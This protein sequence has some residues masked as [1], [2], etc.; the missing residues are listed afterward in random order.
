MIRKD[1]QALRAI[2]VLAVFAYHARPDW[3]PGGFAGVDVF[4]VV[5][6]FLITSHLLTELNKTG[7]ISLRKFFARRAKRLLPASLAVLG[8]STA[9]VWTLAPLALQERFYRDIAAAALYVANWVF[10]ADAVD[11]LGKGNS[12]SIV[13]HFW[14]LGVEE[15]LYFVWPIGLIAV[16]VGLR[17]QRR[18]PRIMF[19]IAGV[20]AASFAYSCV[21]VLQNN[22]LAYFSTLSRAWEFGLGALLATFVLLSPQKIHLSGKSTRALGWAGWTSIAL[23]IVIFDANHGFPGWWALIPVLGTIA[24]IISSNPS[25]NYGLDK[26]VE[27][28]PFQFLGNVS[29]SFYLWHWPL[30]VVSGFYFAR[31]PWYAILL[32]FAVALLL[33][34]TSYKFIENPFRFGKLASIR[35]SQALASVATIMVLLVSAAQFGAAQAGE[36]L[37]SKAEQAS[38][39]ERQVLERIDA[40]QESNFGETVPEQVWDEIS[41]LGPAAIV[42][43]DC[44]QITWDSFVPAVGA[45]DRTAHEI[46]PLKMSGSKIGCL[47]WKDRYD[48]ITCT[49]GVLGGERWVLLGDSHAYQWLPAMNLVAQSNNIELIVMARAGCPPNTT[50]RDAIW[51]HQQ[52]CLSWQGEVLQW[53]S[54]S[55]TPAKVMVSNFAGTPF[56]GGVDKWTLNERAISGYQEFWKQLE[57]NGASIVAFRDTPFPG[58]E[59][60]GCIERNADD[61]NSC[62]LNQAT[63]EKVADNS[64]EA[65]RRAGYPVIDMWPYFCRDTVC[66]IVNG[67]VLTYKDSNHFS[68]TYGLL[69][70]DYLEVELRKLDL[71]SNK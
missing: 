59:A 60:W 14:S 50:K 46:E 13:Q 31:V 17:K 70:S 38:V 44:D 21:L 62:S 19:A 40:T 33:A 29:Y 9:V 10:A 55:T 57:E 28:K 34:Y 12:P 64:L 69:L 43:S 27:F 4:F 11:Y 56:L 66:D 8:F 22:P 25:S 5:S 2:A 65:A 58:D 32:V 49:F 15:Q 37:S 6:G 18:A 68:G 52:G 71:L 16:G 1:I 67:G 48:L 51:D 3:V 39:V 53:F 26:I 7:T 41:C 36:V 30:L 35:P 47:A 45:F 54:Q 23:F 61:P 20:T 42:E 24:V 63:L